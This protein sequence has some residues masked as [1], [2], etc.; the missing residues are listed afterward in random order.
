MSLILKILL[1]ENFQKFCKFIA[2]LGE[3]D[4]FA[5]IIMIIYDLE[6]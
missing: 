3:Q 2:V 1:A 6:T 5:F 4:P